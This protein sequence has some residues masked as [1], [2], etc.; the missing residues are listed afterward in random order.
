MFLKLIK[1]LLKAQ[2]LMQGSLINARL[3]KKV[4]KNFREFSS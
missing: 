3:F 2:T 1:K 4:A